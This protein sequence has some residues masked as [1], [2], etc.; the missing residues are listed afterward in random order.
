M[1]FGLIAL[2]T[3]RLCVRKFLSFHAKAQS[4]Q[5]FSDSDLRA[6]VY[7]VEFLRI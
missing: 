1:N 4:P 3:L 2:G 7:F 6:K 5:S